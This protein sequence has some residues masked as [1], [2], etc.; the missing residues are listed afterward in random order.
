MVLSPLQVLTL[1]V[2]GP[3]FLPFSAKKSVQKND[4]DSA[5]MTDNHRASANLAG[6]LILPSGELQPQRITPLTF[7]RANLLP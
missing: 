7:N 1:L 4:F 5:I 2:G 6:K 3:I